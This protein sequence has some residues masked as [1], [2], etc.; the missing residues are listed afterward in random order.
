[1][2][3]CLRATNDL[4]PLFRSFFLLTPPPPRSTLFPYTTLFRSPAFEPSRALERDIVVLGVRRRDIEPEAQA[5]VER[6]VG[7]VEAPLHA[8]EAVGDRYP[9]LVHE[10]ERRAIACVLAPAGERQIVIVRHGG[11]RHLIL[12]VGVV[13]DPGGITRIGSYLDELPQGR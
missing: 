8:L 7:G 12:P 13:H 5:V 3:K 9:L 1:M 4:P 10:I 6:V 11:A 2:S